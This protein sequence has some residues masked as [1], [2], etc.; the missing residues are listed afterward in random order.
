MYKL[1]SY[2][3]LPSIQGIYFITNIINQKYYLGR[4]VNIKER[5]SWGNLENSHHNNH[6]R[7]SIIKYGR[8]NFIIKVVEYLDISLQEL[9][10]I[11]QGLLDIHVGLPLCYNK[12]KSASGGKVCEIN[13]N[14]GRIVINNGI[15]EKRLSTSEEIP[16]GYIIGRLPSSEETKQKLSDYWTEELRQK[17]SEAYKGEKNPNYGKKCYNNRIKNKYF[18][19]D[20]E[21]PEG[22]I[23]GVTEETRKKQSIAHK[24]E[25]NHC[26]GK[27]IY[28]NGIE[29][30]YFSPDEEI[31]EGF[32][33]G[34]K[35]ET[36]RKQSEA[37]RGENNP[38]FGRKHSSE[39]RNKQSEAKKGK[40]NPKYGKKCY[41]NGIKNKYFSSEEEIPGGFVLGGKPRSKETGQ[42]QLEASCPICA[43]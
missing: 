35:E 39:T 11:E 5:Y 1:E 33:L 3:E 27:N 21:I 25:K 26:Y 30:K 14:Y 9:I 42:K 43:K 7:N 40:N 29:N 41:N 13:P 34:V 23:L 36:K 2:S 32:I 31:P 20:E 24:D 22:F 8:E 16:E 12:S 10:N 38:M 6:L 15:G 4:A 37:N 18:S 19:P 17:Q 28:N